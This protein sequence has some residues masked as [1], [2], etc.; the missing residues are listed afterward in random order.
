MNGYSFCKA[1]QQAFKLLVSNALR[2]TAINSVGDFVLFLGKV[3]VVVSTV[4]IGIEMFKKADGLQHIWV[5]ASLVGLFA[6]FVAHC[7][8]T[9]Y[10]VTCSVID[11]N[12][13]FANILF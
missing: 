5:P 9:V 2:V 1:G 8:L 6:Y 11:Y 7:F 4:L 10:E 13:M 3:L 12:E